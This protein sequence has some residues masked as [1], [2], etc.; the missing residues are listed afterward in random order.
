MKFSNYSYLWPPRPDDAI[1]PQMLPMIERRGY[2]AQ[3]KK[4]GTC[5]VIAVSP[6][7][8]IVAKNRHKEDHK[9]W[10][11][12]TNKLTA[13]TDLPGKGWYVFVAELMHSKVKIEDGGVRNTN[14]I[15]DILVCDGDYLVGTKQVDR[16]RI[17]CDLFGVG[18][19]EQTYSH[20]VYDQHTWIARQFSS[21]FKGLYDS[22]TSVQ[23]EGLVLKDPNTPLQLC[24]KQKSNNGGLLKSRKVHKNYS[25]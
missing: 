12:D 4:N 6:D 15:H 10:R 20:W 3:C 17:L 16:H 14:Y 9:L 21:D 25:F 2:H 22:L 18:E 1:S 23:D 7:K 11:P 8:D 13:F 19:L 24:T 5:S